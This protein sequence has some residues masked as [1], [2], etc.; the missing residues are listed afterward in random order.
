LTSSCRNCPSAARSR[1]FRFKSV[2][3]AQFVQAADAKAFANGGETRFHKVKLAL[4]Q[5]DA[6]VPVDLACEAVEVFGCQQIGVIRLFFEI[7]DL[8]VEARKIVVALDKEFPDQLNVF[9][10]GLHK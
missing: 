6:R 10:V 1:T 5:H 7:D 2:A 9:H 3:I 8:P 4:I